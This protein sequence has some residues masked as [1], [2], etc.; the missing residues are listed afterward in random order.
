M[1][2]DNKKEQEKLQQD[3]EFVAKL[4]VETAGAV[5]GASPAAILNGMTTALYSIT[6]HMYKN[7]KTRKEVVDKIYKILTVNPKKSI[8]VSGGDK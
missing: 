1:T 7:E 4:F 6:A 5:E 3:T 8:I 2:K